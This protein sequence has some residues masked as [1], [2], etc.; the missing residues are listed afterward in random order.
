MIPPDVITAI[1]IED[2]FP[3]FNLFVM[4]DRLMQDMIKS[5]PRAIPACS[6]V[7]VPLLEVLASGDRTYFWRDLR[8]IRT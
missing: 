7:V 5:V 1:V 3:H 6:T 4:G 8:C 2:I